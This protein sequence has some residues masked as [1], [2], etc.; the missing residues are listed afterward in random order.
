MAI[1]LTGVFDDAARAE[2]ASRELEAMGIEGRHIRSHVSESV[3]RDRGR[4]SSEHHGF[5]ARL[6]GADNDDAGLYAEATRRGSTVLTVHLENEERAG[7]VERTLEQAGAIDI[8]DRAEFWRASGYR[9]YDASAQDYTPEQIARDRET[10]EVLQEE[11]RVG[12]R[13][14]ETGGVRVRRHVTEVPFEEQVSLR[15]ERA[16]VDRRPVDRLA[17]PD[18]MHAFDAQDRDIE[19]RETREEAVVDKRARVVEEVSVGTEASER[20]ETVRDTARRTDVD[21]EQLD[22]AQQ[23]QRRTGRDSGMQPGSMR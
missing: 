22:A 7:E 2:Q 23:A 16:V 12:K 15:E 20:V 19:I 14:V 21:V 8:N 17:S 10:F 6:F 13:E 4:R 5:F 1:T 18:E 3:G 9:G 11:I